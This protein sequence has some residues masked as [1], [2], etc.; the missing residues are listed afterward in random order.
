MRNIGTIG[1]VALGLAMVPQQAA[2]EASAI[3]PTA[4]IADTELDAVRGGFIRSRDAALVDAQV[5]SYF[6]V[7]GDVG[8]ITFDNWFV[9]V[10]APL[11]I[12]ARLTAPR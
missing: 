1:L 9:D 8:T 6:R 10:G 12:N 7:S 4:A 5:R 11:I 2:A 3:F